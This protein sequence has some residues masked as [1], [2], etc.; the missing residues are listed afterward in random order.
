MNDIGHY[1]WSM[2]FCCL[3][4]ISVC[5]FCAFVRICHN[6]SQHVNILCKVLVQ[7]VRR[8]KWKTETYFNSEVNSWLNCLLSLHVNK[9]SK[10]QETCSL[11]AHFP[12]WKAGMKAQRARSDSAGK[13]RIS[14]KILWILS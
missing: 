6:A 12:I 13:W 11:H 4:R 1:W 2:P 9:L 5:A 14:G 7:H 8:S 3:L 10:L